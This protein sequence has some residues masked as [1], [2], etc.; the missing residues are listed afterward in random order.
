MEEWCDELRMELHPTTVTDDHLYCVPTTMLNDQCV[1]VSAS[2][3][4]EDTAV[5]EMLGD[6][7]EPQEP[8]PISLCSTTPDEGYSL[9]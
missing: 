6:E 5:S 7:P 9:D 8:C 2:V 1:L 3:D 4:E